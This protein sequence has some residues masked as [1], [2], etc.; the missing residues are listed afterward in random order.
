MD[1]GSPAHDYATVSLE[2]L[3]SGLEGS[4]SALVLGGAALTLPVAFLRQHPAIAVDVV[5]IDASVTELARRYFAVGQY[6]AEAVR[7]CSTTC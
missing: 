6:P 3:R 7:T 1:D 2:L 4:E 5:E